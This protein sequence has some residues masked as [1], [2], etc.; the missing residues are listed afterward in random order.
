MCS[1]SI[2]EVDLEAMSESMSRLKGGAVCASRIVCCCS[3][4]PVL[5][6][7]ENFHVEIS[8][9]ESSIFNVGY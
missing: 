2:E 9:V 7:I 6:F 3:C 1:L 8:T 5:S 4:C